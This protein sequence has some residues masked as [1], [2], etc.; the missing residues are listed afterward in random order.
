MR[1]LYYARH[2][3]SEAIERHLEAQYVDRETLLRESDFVSLHIP[4]SPE[5][6]HAIRA[7]EFSLMKASAFLINASRGKVVDE[8]ALVQALEKKQIA[9]AGL[10]VFE[11]EPK[12]HPK[13]LT[14]SNVVLLP[15]VGSATTET[16]L[17]MAMLAA[18][19]LIALLEGRRPPNVVNPQAFE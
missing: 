4:L 13:L 17:K 8:E 18:E 12:V 3:V 14:M 10:D 6:T 1:V 5:T 11:Q 2:R 15:H 9:G 19:S 16:R 7:L